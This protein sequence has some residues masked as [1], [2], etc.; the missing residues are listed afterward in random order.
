MLVQNIIGIGTDI[1]DLRRLK[2][3]SELR[4][5][6]DFILTDEEMGDMKKS[7]D[8]AQFLASRLAAKEAII[9]AYPGKMSHHDIVI[10]KNGRKIQARLV[11][12]KDAKIGIF[13]SIA[14]ERDYAIG[15]AILYR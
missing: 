14:H 2:K 5:V 11:R 12:S 9:K 7:R 1:V 15:Y 6:A 4:R 13:L 3:V 8:E 10:S